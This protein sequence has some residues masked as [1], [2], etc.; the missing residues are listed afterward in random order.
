MY[1]IAIIGERSDVLGYMSLGFSVHVAND[2][3]TATNVLHKLAKDGTYA[4]IF[5]IEDFAKKME[6]E[7]GKYK[8]SSIPAIIVIPGQKGSEGYGMASIKSAVE[9]AVG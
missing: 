8:N 5:V 9:R 7:I 6:S 1:K 3:E 4:V 2:V